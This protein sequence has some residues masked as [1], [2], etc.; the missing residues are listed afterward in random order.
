MASDILYYLFDDLAAGTS[1]LDLRLLILLNSHK[2]NYRTY[3]P[4]INPYLS[5]IV[6]LLN[7]FAVGILER[8]YN[9]FIRNDV[10]GRTIMPNANSRFLNVSKAI[11]T[12]LIINILKYLHKSL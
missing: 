11:Y 4:N 1:A 5:T 3:Y 6:P 12:S 8:D 2:D 9:M 7:Y 10:L